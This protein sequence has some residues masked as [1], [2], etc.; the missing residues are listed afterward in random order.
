[1]QKRTRPQGQTHPSVA[2]VQANNELLKDPASLRL[3]QA[4]M[5][6]MA[7]DVLV[8]IATWHKIHCEGQMPICEEHLHNSLK[9][10]QGKLVCV[11]SQIGQTSA[12]IIRMAVKR[13]ARP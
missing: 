4:A 9:A 12:K 7:D 8:Q 1:M 11:P 5:G 13:G 6:L 2:E 10:C 3:T